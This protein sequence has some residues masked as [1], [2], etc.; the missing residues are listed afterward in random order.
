MRHELEKLHAVIITGFL[1]RNNYI[2]NFPLSG[3]CEALQNFIHCY[4]KECMN[5]DPF[6]V[7]EYELTST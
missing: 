6:F 5:L 7:S 2:V 4:A 3:D 1:K